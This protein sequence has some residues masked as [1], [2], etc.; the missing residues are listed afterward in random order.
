MNFEV[1]FC[2]LTPSPFQG[3]GWGEGCILKF[4][5]KHKTLTLTL[6]LEGREYLNQTFDL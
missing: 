1:Q 6:S 4:A 2:T 3:E 5:S